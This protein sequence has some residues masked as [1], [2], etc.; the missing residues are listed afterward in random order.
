MNH[1]EAAV[2]DRHHQTFPSDGVIGIAKRQHAIS[3]VAPR[4]AV[5]IGGSIANG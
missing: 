3:G 4:M 5:W 1:T 2:V